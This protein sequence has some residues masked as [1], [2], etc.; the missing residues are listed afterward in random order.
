MAIVGDAYDDKKLIGD[1]GAHDKLIIE[2]LNIAFEG[3]LRSIRGDVVIGEKQVD[4]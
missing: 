1:V 3:Y 4:D 2:G